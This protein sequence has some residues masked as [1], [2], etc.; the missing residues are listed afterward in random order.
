MSFG[1]SFLHTYDVNGEKVYFH[2]L[3]L[4]L[5]HSPEECPSPE[6]EQ[7]LLASYRRKAGE[8]SGIV[9]GC[10]FLTTRCTRNCGYCF[11]QDVQQG[12]MTPAEI[13]AGLDLMGR[14][15]ADLLM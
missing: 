1:S 14:G 11:L 9:M 15:P 6:R 12:D 10:M 5:Y 3:T 2:S 4:E 13:D 7:E 8:N